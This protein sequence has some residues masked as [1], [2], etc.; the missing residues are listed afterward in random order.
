VK[1][2]RE[3][4]AR[5][6]DHAPTGLVYL[7]AALCI[8][9]ANRHCT[10][11]LGY[12]PNEMLGRALAEVLDPA[13]LRY[14]RSHAA[15]LDQG[16]DGPLN[17]VLRHRDGSPRTLSVRAIADY[18]LG[19]RKLGYFACTSDCDTDRGTSLQ[20]RQAR[21]RLGLVLDTA[22]ACLWDWDLGSRQVCYSSGFKRLL[23]YD[24]A[25]FP[26]EFVFFS[27]LHP[28]DAERTL[29]AVADAIESGMPFDDEFRM[30]CAGGSFRWLR[31]V[32]R[33]RRSE[34]SGMVVRFSG[35]VC[36]ISIRK[37]AQLRLAET[38]RMVDA[39]LDR[40]GYGR[41]KL[42]HELRT[43]L[44]SVIAA[45]ELMQE[46]GPPPGTSTD[47]ATADQDLVKLALENADRLARLV[48]RLLEA[49]CP[50]PGPAAA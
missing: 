15:R 39:I 30:R 25:N 46:A 13:T 7:D 18:D 23:G 42:G 45:L 17:Y 35:T 28:E 5:V 47:A 16:D 1:L 21:E 32:G 43:P 22:G 33:T 24:E 10:D 27:Q 31:G 40:N 3:I 2:P 20:L 34:A 11:L 49:E 44:A 4:A 9:F 29:D 50:K 36:D 19:G 48:E 12:A 6:A 26:R 8:R 41:A 38:R 14:A 37:E